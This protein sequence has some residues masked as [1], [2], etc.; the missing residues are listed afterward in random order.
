MVLHNA[1]CP[2]GLLQD[3]VRN[4]FYVSKFG[5]LYVEFEFGHEMAKITIFRFHGFMAYNVKIVQHIV[6]GVKIYFLTVWVKSSS[7][8]CHICTVG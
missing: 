1:I 8:F 4:G 3:M 5:N 6:G 2:L 7:D